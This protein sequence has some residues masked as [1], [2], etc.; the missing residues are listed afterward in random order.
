MIYKDGAIEFTSGTRVKAR[1]I[2]GLDLDGLDV[3]YGADG[4][5]HLQPGPNADLNDEFLALSK[6][7]QV[8][9]ADYMI[10]KW[11][12]FR[13]LATKGEDVEPTD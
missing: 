8:E 12:E 3:H 11:L 4:G 2:I 6:A 13:N 10:Q 7:D 5:I 9:L 1:R